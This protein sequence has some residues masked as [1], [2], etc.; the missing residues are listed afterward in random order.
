M[1]Y[2]VIPAPLRVG[3][4]EFFFAE[5]VSPLLNDQRFLAPLKHQR[6]AARIDEALWVDP[7]ADAPVA[8]HQPG[9]VWALEDQA[10]ELLLA[11]MNDPRGLTFF[12]TRRRLLAFGEALEKATDK[13][14]PLVAV[15]K[16][17]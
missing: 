14:P 3:E 2:I 17:A 12:P 11:S 13:P 1:K 6:L 16:T 7:L 5:Y 9:D 10:H 4:K 15:D 8:R